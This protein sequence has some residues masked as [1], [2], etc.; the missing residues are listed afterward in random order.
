MSTEKTTQEVTRHLGGATSLEPKSEFERELLQQQQRYYDLRYKISAALLVA[1]PALALLPPRKIDFYTFGLGSA[2]FYCLTEVSS[3]HGRDM[4]RGFRRKEDITPKMA[5]KAE[6]KGA[7]VGGWKGEIIKDY[8]KR[9][10][11]ADSYGSIIM[12]QIWDV[13][14]QRDRNKKDKKTGPEA[15]VREEI[16]KKIEE[17]KRE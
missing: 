12:E 4:W 5:Q 13:W 16:L 1:C 8:K 14:E 10:E 3:A 2:W 9:E 6:V 17:D 7:K 15:N 11:E